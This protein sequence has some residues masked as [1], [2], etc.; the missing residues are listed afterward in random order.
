[1]VAGRCGGRQTQ[2]DTHQAGIETAK[3][4]RARRGVEGTLRRFC[5]A[6]RLE[7]R[8]SRT[9]NTSRIDGIVRSLTAY[10]LSLFLSLFLSLSLPPLRYRHVQYEWVGLSVVIIKMAT[11]CRAAF[12]TQNYGLEWN[13]GVAMEVRSTRSVAC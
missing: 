13:Q 12:E 1:M 5:S 3:R 2:P 4:E 9:P 7:V 6:E 10:A 11:C 8:F